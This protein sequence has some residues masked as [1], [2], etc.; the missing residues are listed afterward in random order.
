LADV[1][2]LA[3]GDAPIELA[4]TDRS[5]FIRW[6]EAVTWYHQAGWSRLNPEHL[7]SLASKK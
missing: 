7:R 1:A 4:R 3:L 6:R 5:L 2:E